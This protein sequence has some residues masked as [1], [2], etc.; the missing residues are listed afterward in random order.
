MR[1]PWVS[2]WFITVSLMLSLKILFLR[3]CLMLVMMP[4]PGETVMNKK[5]G[6]YLSPHV[7][8]TRK[9]QTDQIVTQ[10]NE[11]LQFSV[12]QRRNGGIIIVYNKGILWAGAF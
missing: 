11:K 7:A 3:I 8:A 9:D 10:V 4:G 2:P 5:T 12:L 1:W 6:S